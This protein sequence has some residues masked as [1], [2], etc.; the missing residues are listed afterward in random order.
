MI[1]YSIVEIFGHQTLDGARVDVTGPF[2]IIAPNSGVITVNTN[3]EREALVDGFHY[4][5]IIVSVMYIKGDSDHS[6]YFL[7]FSIR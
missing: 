5:E 4:Y 6:R 7:G 2:F 3:L 1:T